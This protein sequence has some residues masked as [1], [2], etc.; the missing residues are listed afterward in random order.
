MVS[1]PGLGRAISE[2]LCSDC[3]FSCG[4]PQAEACGP[5]RNPPLRLGGRLPERICPVGP[6][7]NRR[8]GCGSGVRP[9]QH[10]HSPL[11]V[12]MRY[13]RCRVAVR[14][15]LPLDPERAVPYVHHR[16]AVYGALPSTLDVEWQCTVRCP[17]RSPP[18]GSVRRTA[19]R[20]RTYRTHCHSPLIV[21][22]RYARC[23]VA[24]RA[25]LPLDPERAATYVHRRVAVYGAPSGEG[26]QRVPHAR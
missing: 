25:A 23:R 15:A 8:D 21:P 2:T 1:R 20:P 19:T 13:A 14:A 7:S 18:S 11:N 4:Q 9:G 6:L 26:H 3:A 24:V 12:P 22:I 10:C 16:V 5:R 17:A